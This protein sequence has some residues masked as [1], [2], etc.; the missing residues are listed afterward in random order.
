[1]LDE[2]TCCIDIQSLS[3]YYYHETYVA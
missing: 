3:R 1:V 2:N